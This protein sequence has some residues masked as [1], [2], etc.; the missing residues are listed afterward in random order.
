MSDIEIFNSEQ[1]MI[2]NSA[3]LEA[4]KEFEESI[5]QKH[6]KVS[7]TKTNPN[8]VKQKAGM[9]YVEFA[10]MK[11]QA[12]YYYPIWGTK[13]LVIKHEMINAG[14]VVV[15][16]DLYWI[17]DG[18]PRQGV[19]AAA[20]RIAFKKDHE[21]I[22]E[23]IVDLSNDVKAAVTD[24]LKKGFNTYMN[25][26]DDIYRHLE[27]EDI[28]D[29][30]KELLYSIVE[31]CDPSRQRAFYSFV[32]D[33]TVKANLKETFDKL[34]NAY[35]LHQVKERDKDSILEDCAK[36]VDKFNNLQK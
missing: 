35:K 28:T 36:F 25:I 11:G 3:A 23:N 27:I 14:W 31:G 18:I 26:S 33:S 30:Q 9:D 12:N 20:H 22:P 34:I 6:K 21:R 32:D 2:L 4:V 16:L 24:A 29:E 13:N 1:K 15:Q 8:H 7:D 19:C 17:D 5:R 10:Y